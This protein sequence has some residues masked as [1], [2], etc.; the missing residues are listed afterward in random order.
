MQTTFTQALILSGLIFTVVQLPPLGSKTNPPVRPDHSL[1][2]ALKVPEDV[3]KILTS[4]CKNCHS[5]QTE[6]PW[7]ARVAP[8]S[9]I[10]ARDVARGRRYP[11]KCT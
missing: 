10:L 8:V 1:E 9:W 3:E 4:A 2:A 6:W 5:N 7:Y 11:S